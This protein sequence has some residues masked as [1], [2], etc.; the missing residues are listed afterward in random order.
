MNQPR[1]WK[2]LPA[3]V[4]VLIRPMLFLSLGLHALLLLLPLPGERE[5]EPEPEPELLPAE[6]AIKVVPAP[7][8]AAGKPLTPKPTSPSPVA[9]PTRPAAPPRSSPTTPPIVASQPPPPVSNQPTPSASPRPSEPEAPSSPP[10]IDLNAPSPEP[11]PPAAAPTGAFDDFPKPEGTVAGCLGLNQ[12]QQAEG[13][14]LTRLVQDLQT[15]L[16]RQGYA[17]TAVDLDNDQGRRVFEVTKGEEKRYLNLFSTP[18]GTVYLLAEQILTLAEVEAMAAS[19]Q[20]LVTLVQ[21]L[22][23]QQARGQ[24]FTQPNAFFTEM[25][26]RE[27]LEPF[28]PLVAAQT[29]DRLWATQLAP[30]LQQQGFT[31]A[32]LPDY[33]GGPLYQVQQGALVYYLSLVPAA[34]G[35]GAIVTLWSQMPRP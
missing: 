4:R 8:L 14:R 34:G 5:P 26:L 13:V 6:Q 9:K 21:G 11:I 23:N 35:Q 2:N 7:N 33:A 28:F 18:E 17:V 29:P 30:Q 32:P 31:V 15:M 22:S 27:G 16:E 24:D 19:R 10:A 20:A 12:C 3:P 1:F 25:G